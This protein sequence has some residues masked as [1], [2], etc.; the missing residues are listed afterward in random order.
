MKAVILAGGRGTRLRPLT[1]KI[2]KALIPINNKTLTELV[3]DVLKKY[4]IR[5]ILLSVAYK[6]DMIKNKFKDGSGYGLN[7]S[8]IEEPCP[9]GTAGP[10]IIL[11]K[12][13]RTI[14]ETFFMIN[15]D[16]LCKANL[17]KMLEFHKENKAVATIALTKV[18][19][20]CRY[21]VAELNKNKISQFMEKPKNPPSN[22]INSGYYILEPEVFGLTRNREKAMMEKDIFPVLAKQ[23]KLFGFKSDALWFDTGTFERYEKVKKEWKLD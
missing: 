3:F 11:N 19:N 8:Y 12:E 20:P 16:N 2:P 13:N 23:G 18:E 7:I 17:Q 9:L 5:D 21:G 1:Y 4:G 10:L 15:G 6:A 22:Y 14:K